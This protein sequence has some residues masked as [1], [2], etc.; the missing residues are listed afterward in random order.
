MKQ[1]LHNGQLY[2]MVEAGQKVESVLIEDGKI[3]ATGKYEDLADLADTAI[4]LQGATLFP[5]FV[6]SHLHMIGTGFKLSRLDLSTVE[7]AEEMLRLIAEEAQ[8]SKAG[9]WVWVEGFNENNFPDQRIPTMQELDKIT[10]SPLIISRVCRHVYLGNR[11][12]FELAGITEATVDPPGGRIGRHEDGSLNGLLYENATELLKAAVPQEGPI[13]R[14]S[15]E[16][17]LHVTINQMHANGLTGGHSEEMAYFGPYINVYNAYKNVLLARQDFRANL[18]IHN[19]VFTEI[20]EEQLEFDED[21]MALGAMKIFADGSFGGSTA[22]LLAPYA[23]DPTTSGMLIQT[24]SQM[25]QLFQLAT[26]YARPIAV[27]VIGDAAAQQIIELIEKYPPP[28]NTKHRIIHACLL[29]EE[30]LTRMSK[31]ELAVDIQ[32]QFVTSDFPWVANKIGP[33]RL[34]F[35]Y[36]WK[37]LLEA[38]I[39]C[40]GGS[41]SPIEVVNPLE[42]IYAAVTRKKAGDTHSGYVA[43]Q[44]ITLFE[45]L[46]LYTIGSAEI[47]NHAHDRGIIRPGYVADFT[48]FNE[49]LLEMPIEQ[50]LE[51]TVKMTIVNGKIVY[52]NK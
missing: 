14:Q 18:L 37:A 39:I 23:D 27:H 32:P 36:P 35:A 20:M 34:A 48:V 52:E 30:L 11:L 28:V 43:E 22:A 50:L 47:I 21:F 24:D 29:N 8:K 46:R 49:N 9:Q 17:A 40:A 33:S 4:D 45:A 1:I 26:N 44:K 51:A 2:T 15:L 19:E 6:D 16:N 12:G 31:L 10:T 5:G 41:D 38:G 13:Y 3:I 25:E 42:G 7:S